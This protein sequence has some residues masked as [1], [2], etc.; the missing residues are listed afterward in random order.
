MMVER[1]YRGWRVVGRLKDGATAEQAQAEADVV[2][3]N[4]A[5]QFPNMNK[6]LGI[7]VM[8]LLEW[9]V[10][11]LRFT[12]LLLFGTVGVVLLIACSNVANL[13]LERAVSR[14]REITVR[15]ALGASR[16]RIARQL[17]TES[18]MLALAGGALGS[19]LAMWG[20][21]L[22]VSLSPEGITRITETRLDARVLVFTAAISFLTGVLFGLAPAMSISPAALAESLKEG[23]RSGGGGLRSGRARNLLVIAEVSLALVLLVGAGLL[24]RTLVRL[25]NVP[26][27]FDPHNVLTMIVAK[28]PGEPEQTGE[29]YRQLTERIKALPGVVNASVTWQ[30]PLSGASAST[31][32]EIEGQPNEPGG[33]PVGVIHSAGPG[34]FRTMGIPIREGRDFTDRD[35]LKSAPVIIV[36]ETLAKRFFPAGDAIGKHITPSFATTGGTKKR[37]IIGVVGDVKHQSLKGDIVHEFYFPQ[38]QMPVTSMTVVVRTSVDPHA[39]AGAVRK[40]VQS[41]DGN[42]PDLQRR[43][44]GGVPR[45]LGRV[46]SLQHDAARGFRRRGVAA[47]GGWSLRSDILLCQ[48][49]HARNRNP[50]GARRADL[51]RA[52]AG[53][54]PGHGFDL[55]GC[56]RRPGSCVL[57]DALDVESSLR[58]WRYR[59]RDVRGRLAPARGGGRTRLLRPGAACVEGRSDGSAT[60]RVTSPTWTQSEPPRGSGW[61][62]SLSE[63]LTSYPPATA[64]GTD[65]VQERFAY[66]PSL[67]CSCADGADVNEQYPTPGPR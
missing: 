9:L 46:H 50:H 64:G 42:A 51:R 17:V 67:H 40:E 13:L 6:D 32:L 43:D 7:K 3:S 1:G 18:L 53:Y 38:A 39:L 66:V 24:V 55:R 4:L 33:F 14:Q 45:T 44:S 48:P 8:P 31:G 57:V 27:G 61:V 16:W 29:F 23:G 28:S 25:Q 10:G 54:G 52:Q 47:D 30:L 65:C 36:N 20:T 19:L 56:R 5:V 21:K 15:L 11:N 12:L 26:L 62:R 22:I 2:A 34:Y 37:E 58:R 49:V 63:R 59:L 41:M 60:L 35:D